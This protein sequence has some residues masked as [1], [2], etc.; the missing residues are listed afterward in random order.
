[1]RFKKLIPL[2]ALFFLL[3]LF[4]PIPASG[5]T[6]SAP[7]KL[8]QPLPFVTD[9]K[10]ETTASTYIPGIVKLAIAA[11]GALAVIMIVVGGVE[12][13]STDAIA[14][15]TG[16]KSRISNALWGLALAI[17]AWTILNTVNPD[18]VNLDIKLATQNLGPG[19]EEGTPPPEPP[20]G[21]I[22]GDPQPTGT[23]WGDDTATRRGIA[24]LLKTNLELGAAEDGILI[25]KLNCKKVGDTNCTSVY[26]LDQ[27]AI[28]SLLKLHIACK[29]RLVITGGTE[30]WLHSENTA[31]NPDVGKGKV[32]DLS[33]SEPLETFLKTKGRKITGEG[34]APGEKYAYDGGIYVKEMGGTAPHWHVC[35][36]RR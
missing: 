7:Y 36:L 26:R 22:P 8:L 9:A 30:Y 29:C 35:L 14:G 17:G 10:G 25:N 11:A 19:F 2:V 12:Y 24:T 23:P 20:I 31:H 15:K 32:V 18:L 13:M 33:L 1:M 5:Q 6:D 3:P 4:T 16:A 34:C 27:S 21:T 28:L